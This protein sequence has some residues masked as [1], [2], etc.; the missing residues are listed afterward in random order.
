MKFLSVLLE[1]LI[2]VRIVDV[3][4]RIADRGE[5]ATKKLIKGIIDT[6]YTD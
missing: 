2:V 4:Y 6:D 1:K 3:V 5:L